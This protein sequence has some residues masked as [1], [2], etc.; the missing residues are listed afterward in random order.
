VV[1]IEESGKSPKK[2]DFD[3]P[4][5]VDAKGKNSGFL[6]QETLKQHEPLDAGGSSH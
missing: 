4:G 5:T 2:E 6:T 1:A 3:I